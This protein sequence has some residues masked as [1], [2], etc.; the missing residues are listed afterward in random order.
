[1]EGEDGS[2]ERILT[3]DV[4]EAYRDKVSLTRFR[5]VF[6]TVRGLKS[7]IWQLFKICR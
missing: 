3:D 7:G 2:G 4:D 1:M 5:V 6:S